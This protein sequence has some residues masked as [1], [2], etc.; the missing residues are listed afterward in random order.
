MPREQAE[1]RSGLEGVEVAGRHL[2]GWFVGWRGRDDLEGGD[3]VRVRG[4]LVA[5]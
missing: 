3:R 4:D 2:V 1:R 5:V